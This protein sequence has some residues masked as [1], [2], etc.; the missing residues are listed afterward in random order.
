MLNN[1]T[2]TTGA[3]SAPTD[4]NL[5]TIPSN[6]LAVPGSSNTGLYYD[7]TSGTFMQQSAQ[8]PVANEWAWGP[9]GIETLGQ[10]PSPEGIDNSFLAIQSQ[11]ANGQPI[12]ADTWQQAVQDSLTGFVR[13]NYSNSDPIYNWNP[14]SSGTTAGSQYVLGTLQDLANQYPGFFDTSGPQTINDATGDIVSG[15][16]GGS[17]AISNIASTYDVLAGLN[18]QTKLL[19]FNDTPMNQ[20][21]QAVGNLPGQF[22]DP[23]YINAASG[24]A[25]DY[26]SIQN[27]IAQIQNGTYQQPTNSN[28]QT[29]GSAPNLEALMGQAEMD[30]GD[31]QNIA[32]NPNTPEYLSLAQLQAQGGNYNDL[33]FQLNINPYTPSS[34]VTTANPTDVLSQFYNTPA[35]QL[36][37]GNYAA[38][39]PGL[40]PAQL[41]QAEPG[42]AFQQQ[43]GAYQLENLQSQQG[44][45]Q[46][47]QGQRNLQQYAQGLADQ[48]YQNYLA[49][50]Q[51]LFTNWTNG[52]AGVAQQG[53]TASGQISQ[54][55]TNLGN[56]LANSNTN[57][58][59]Q[60]S[61]GSLSTGTNIAN[62]FGNQG[63]FGSSAILNT[64][65]AQS[66]NVMSAAAI[67]AQIA[68]AQASANASSNSSAMSGIGSLLGAA[69]GGGG[70]GGG[71]F[72]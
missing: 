14:N 46:S 49:Q 31:I 45:L 48:D 37:F 41:F 8:T 52:I 17:T 4:T 27:E 67:Q 64:A 36:A 7:P 35:Y 60:L 10:G 1:N 30:L 20:I 34:P 40:S 71:G 56:A 68:A 54:N 57:T 2:S 55:N 23:A 33:L 28:G 16:G 6:W 25:N 70:G 43:Q 47:G 21:E 29:T 15:A 9:Q 42:Y 65:A 26:Y 38:N 11:Y 13:S 63:A 12:T 19:G 50:N 5:T 72:F 69:G 59:N 18:P 61:S 62:L 39:N 58:G 24:Y 3:A 66:S 44:L 53:A 32:A 51:Q 22:I